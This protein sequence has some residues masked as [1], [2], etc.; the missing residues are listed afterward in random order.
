MSELTKQLV[1][2]PLHLVWGA[3]TG[4]TLISS[5]LWVENPWTLLMMLGAAGSGWY[6]TRRE[7]LQFRD[8]AHVSWDPALDNGVFWIGLVGGSALAHFLR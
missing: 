5:V 7:R 3:A 8:G 4:A 6:W 1:D 2:Q